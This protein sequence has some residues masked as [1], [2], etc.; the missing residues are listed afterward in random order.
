MA[1]ATTKESKYDLDDIKKFD[2]EFEKIFG[3]KSIK[4]ANEY[5]KNI[6]VQRFNSIGLDKASG[7]GGLPFGRIVEIVG[8]ESSG[9]TTICLE[10]LAQYLKDNPDKYASFID[11]EHSLDKAYA[12][13]VG[14]DLN[15]LKISEPMT[16]EQGLDMTVKMVES[17]LFKVIVVDS[18]AALIPKDVIE[19]GMEAQKMGLQARVVGKGIEKLFA[20]VE[21][22]DVLLVIPNQF[23]EK[24]GVM[25]GCLHYDNT[26]LFDDGRAIPIGE[27]VNKKIKGNVF[28]FNEKT[29]KIESK[30]IV[31]WHNNGQVSKKEDFISILTDSLDARGR[32][33]ITC[34]TNHKLLTNAGW[35]EAKDL[36]IN[37]KLI[38]KYDSIFNGTF[39][40]FLRGCII[41][42]SNLSKN[43]AK[44]NIRIQNSTQSEYL[45]WK[46]NKLSKYLIFKEFKTSRGTKYYASNYTSEFDIIKKDIINRDPLFL[47]NNY[48]DLGMAIWYMDDGHYDN[49]KS[50][51]RIIISVKRFKN[52]VYVLDTIVNKLKDIFNTEEIHY[53]LKDGAIKFTKNST[54][55]V[56]K[57]IAK[58]IPNCMNYKLD[59]I[60]HN[61]YEEFELECIKEI[62]NYPVNILKI[63]SGSSRKFRN[64]GKYDISVEG[65]HNYMVGSPQNG[66][67]V[68]NSPD[69]AK[70]GNTLK[71]YATI[72]MEVSRS[73]TKLNSI[74]DENDTKLGN[75]TKVKFLKNKVAP[76]FT[77]CEFYIR[78]NE[79]IDRIKEII[80]HGV[81]LN[82]IKKSGSFFSYKDDKLGQGEA[83]LRATL[84][85]NPDLCEEI[86]QLILQNDIVE[87]FEPKPEE[88]IQNES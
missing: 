1:K 17:G 41:G 7:V 12:E 45:K 26:L 35:K 13:K 32:Y 77:S 69:V 33:G 30:P 4:S 66:I 53:T 74:T 2:E 60:F 28:T 51:N 62:K 16:A 52:N 34:T 58:Y 36:N 56:F 57:R 78:Y 8:W 73:T 50:H 25:F 65:N 10:I 40:D 79:G 31:N 54:I 19:S 18:L 87:V 3:K 15:R 5:D 39:S 75:L 46:L 59:S 82:I 70:C 27:V 47:L 42:D 9:K 88:I 38:S 55:E 49:K 37:D 68:H 44:V 43:K 84:I 64:K 14:V 29:G 63:T 24:I 76:P 67:I 22:N 23:R 72:R 20:L 48:S 71:F 81:S 80:D 61:K 6:K 21:K 86:K 83:Q 11:A 85:D